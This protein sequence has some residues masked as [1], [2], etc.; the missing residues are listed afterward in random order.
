MIQQMQEWRCCGSESRGSVNG[1]GIGD[2]G[3]PAAAVLVELV[4]SALH[5]AESFSGGRGRLR[6]Y[7]GLLGANYAWHGAS[8]WCSQRGKHKKLVDFSAIC[9]RPTFSAVFDS[10]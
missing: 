2:E 4:C 9:W 8:G 10:N 1:D 5:Q 7:R 6:S 3:I